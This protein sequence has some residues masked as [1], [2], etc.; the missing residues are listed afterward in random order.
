LLS[1]LDRSLKGASKQAVE[2][3]V[4]E[5]QAKLSVGTIAG[6]STFLSAIRDHL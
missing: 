2:L 3:V 4:D 1:H 5:R 6:Q